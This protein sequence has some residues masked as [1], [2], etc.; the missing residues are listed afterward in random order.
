MA[1]KFIYDSD[2]DVLKKLCNLRLKFTTS[3]KFIHELVKCCWFFYFFWNSNLHLHGLK[4]KSMVLLDFLT[5]H[6]L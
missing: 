6:V 3:G 4:T 1:L 5:L 2:T